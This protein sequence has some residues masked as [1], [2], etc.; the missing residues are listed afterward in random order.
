LNREEFSHWIRQIFR[1]DETEI[2]CERLQRLL[3]AVVDMENGQNGNASAQTAFAAVR[4]HLLQCRDCHD[5]YESLR[6]IAALENNGRLPE[7]EE[8]LEAI[9]PAGEPART[10]TAG[11][12]RMA[13]AL[14]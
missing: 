12:D 1:T 5:V 14:S 8:S 4:A 3:P 2:D 11:S 9:V 6:Q 10:E 7:V 13:A